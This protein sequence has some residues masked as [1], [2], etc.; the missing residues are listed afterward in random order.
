MD[1][2]LTD[3][4]QR[5]PEFVMRHGGLRFYRVPKLGHPHIGSQL[6]RYRDA[7]AACNLIAKLDGMLAYANATGLG[8]FGAETRTIHAIRKATGAS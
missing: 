8:D 3:L 5:R 4:K 7:K 1:N 6:L 2:A